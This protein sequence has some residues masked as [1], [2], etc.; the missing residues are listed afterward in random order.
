MAMSLVFVP[1][2]A[3]DGTDKL[4]DWSATIDSGPFAGKSVG[5]GMWPTDKSVIEIAA[6]TIVGI[7]VE[8]AYEKANRP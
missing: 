4:M 6:K 5:C 1:S 7:I 3:T 8:T 2:G